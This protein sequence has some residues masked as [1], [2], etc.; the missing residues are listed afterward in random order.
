M[1]LMLRFAA[2]SDVGLI[3]TNNE[4]A[5]YA[6]PRLVA[7]ADGMGGHA[8]GD[9]ASAV[10]IA[11]LAPLDDDDPPSDLLGALDQSIRQANDQL[12][13]M[14]D[15]DSELDGMGTTL[16]ALL[17]S[18]SR[19]AL[20]HI[21][22]SRAYLM[23]DGELTQITHDHTLV[24]HMVDEGQLDEA[25]IPTHPQRSV[26]LRVLN[27]RPDIEADLSVRE[28]RAG[29]RY[30]LCSDGLS[31]VVSKDTLRDT[32]ALPDPEQVVD[33]L[34]DLALRGGAP[35]NVTCVVCDVV[36]A[37]GTTSGAPVIGGSVADG[38]D[39]RLREPDTAAGRAAALRDHRRPTTRRRTED[40]PTRRRWRGPALVL[41]LVLVVAGAL[42][43]GT[44]LYSQHQFYVGSN[45]QNVVV[46]KGINGRVL[47]ISFSSPVENTGITMSSLPTFERQRVADT[48]S[49]RN[50]RDADRIVGQLHASPS[51]SPSPAT[52]GG[53]SP[54]P[55][56]S[57]ITSASPSGSP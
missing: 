17:W 39:A 3:R 27:G 48:I 45:G 6:G 4:D 9:V 55:G 49:A 2:R 13:Q 15:A 23:R 36:E 14:M 1:S 43:G 38:D 53:S 51:A 28:A 52:P 31:G 20:A 30:L 33:A 41:V 40:E 10:T 19:L 50:R 42:F 7:V 18:G 11:T 22:D 54:S 34:I 8:A 35:D 26:I 37:A 56:I 57:A 47:G 44:W 24:Q 46:Y 16:T 21:G 25:D 12:R 29:D 32:L 5:V